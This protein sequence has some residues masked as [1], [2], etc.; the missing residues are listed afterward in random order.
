M[1]AIQPLIRSPPQKKN[2]CP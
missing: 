2:N 1:G